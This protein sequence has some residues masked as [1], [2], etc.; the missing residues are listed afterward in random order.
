M[1]TSSVFIKKNLCN[2]MF[3]YITGYDVYN[4]D[5][6]LSYDIAHATFYHVDIHLIKYH[7]IHRVKSQTLATKNE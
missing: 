1:C 7:I 2:K 6:F 5:N 3:I 4:R